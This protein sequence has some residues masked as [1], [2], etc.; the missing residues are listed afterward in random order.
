MR[1]LNWRESLQRAGSFFATRDTREFLLWCLPALV[2][3]LALR[4]ALTVS[5]PYGYYHD[6][7]VDFLLTPDR[8]L[9]SF[10]I[11]VH[12]KKTFLV[13]AIYTLPFLVGV[14]ALIV[15]PLLQHTLGLGLVLL[16]GLLCRFWL[17]RWRLFILPLTVL[18]AVNPFYLAFEHTL[19]AESIFVFT[20]ALLAVAGTLY[21]LEQT[22]ARFAFLLVA[23]FFEAAAR[24]EGKLLFGFGIL[25]VVVLHARS[26]RAHWLRLAA[27]LLLALGT[28]FITKT[29]QAGLLLYTSVARFTPPDLK[30]A[31]GFEPYIAPLR[32]QL[33]RNWDEFRTFPRVRDRKEIGRAVEQYLREQR[34]LTGK[35]NRQVDALCLAMAK[36]TCRRN[37][38]RLPAH[39]FA[40]FHAVATE[41][42]NDPF[43]EHILL[44][45]QR[46]ALHAAG[47]RAFRL[48]R[49]LTG[50]TLSDEAAIDQ[51]VHSNYREVPWFNRWQQIWLAAVNRLRLPDNYVADPTSPA[52]PRRIP[53]LPLYFVAA[54][55]GLIAAAIPS[56]RLQPF[57]VAWGLAFVGFFFVLMLTANVRPR[58][59]FVFEPYWF[60]YFAVF[61]E[62]VCIPAGERFRELTAK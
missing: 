50:Q 60:L 47:K 2:V 22:R 41:A 6:D 3:G 17:T 49:G 35:I 20:T 40:K 62:T 55:L 36:E 43:D 9:N 18:A 7:T 8:L 51:F 15:L 10:S 28:H 34:G 58:F 38:F 16:I 30:S 31:P 32:A 48:S 4:V 53:G 12:T 5:L 26:W 46:E 59:R 33:Q 1:S 61:V 11:S 19:I 37:L 45:K 21:A 44:E 14:P 42:P 25:L 54:A 13:P 39:A 57:H 24:P 52:A 27:V 23:L 56:R 29:G